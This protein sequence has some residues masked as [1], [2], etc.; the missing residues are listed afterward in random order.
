MTTVQVPDA[1]SF[2]REHSTRSTVAGA[3]VQ[4]T[5]GMMRR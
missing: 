5:L 2:S 3:F 4:G 1:P